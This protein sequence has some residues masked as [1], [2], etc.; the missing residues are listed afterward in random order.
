M[1]YLPNKRALSTSAPVIDPVSFVLHAFAGGP[2]PGLTLVPGFPTPK[3]L[4]PGSLGLMGRMGALGRS[5]ASSALAFAD[6]VINGQDPV[7]IALRQLSIVAIT[8]YGTAVQN[9]IKRSGAVLAC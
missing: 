7:A 6:Y 1:L 9:S 2:L 3:P 8:S 4:T 5:E